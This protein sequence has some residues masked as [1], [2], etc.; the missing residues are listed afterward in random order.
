MY[1]PFLK[2]RWLTTS[3]IFTSFVFAGFLIVSGYSN[4]QASSEEPMLVA[5]RTAAKAKKRVYKGTIFVAATSGGHV[6]KATVTIDPSNKKSPIT[7]EKLKR[8]MITMERFSL[9]RK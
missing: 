1:S 6:A 3:V 4:S 2:S 7:V 5:K 8:I 9:K